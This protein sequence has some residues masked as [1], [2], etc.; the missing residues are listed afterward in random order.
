MMMMRNG[1]SRLASAILALLLATAMPAS[2][3]PF[4][5]YVDLRYRYEYQHHF[6]AKN[7]G[8]QPASGESCDGFW[9]QRLRLG[10]SW[11]PHQ[12]L[13]LAVG[14]QDARVFDSDLDEEGFFYSKKND[15]QNNA[16]RDE[17]E[18]YET[19]VEIREL[20]TPAW[21]LRVGRQT[22]EYGDNRIFGPGSWGNS[23]RYQWD[24]VKLSYR[25]NAHFIDFIWGGY[26]LH[27]PTQLSLRHRHA[28]YG[29]GVYGHWQ[30]NE[31]TVLEPFFLIKYDRHED[32]G[33]EQ[34]QPKGDLQ[35][36]NLGA[37]LAALEGIWFYD[38][39]LVQ[40]WG[41][42]GADRLRAWGAHLLVG[43]RFA[44]LPLQPAL[45]LEYS[46]ASGDADPADGESNAFLGVF[47]ARDRMYGRLNL[48]DWTNLHDAQCNLHL[49]P[50]KQVKLQ[51]E[52][53]RFW[54][55]Q[56]RDGWSLNSSRY[57]DKTGNSG[58][59]L[60]DELDLI[61][62][63]TLPPLRAVKKENIELLFGYSRFWPGEFAEKQADNS[64]ADWL[65]AQISYKRKF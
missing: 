44:H 1:F 19:F 5:G 15:H 8:E 47:G 40:Q 56:E 61:L 7:Y 53:H 58:R 45:S 20:P 43:R 23:G 33:S 38:A 35:A 10:G 55:D 50:H 4:E 13:K 25:R 18:L 54:L 31:K 6:N 62:T 28:G 63:W 2:A 52:G 41:D 17:W 60:G 51:I 29:G 37:R 48:L 34:G 9:L 42:S 39:T 57:R 11:Q 14:L 49:K 36:Y 64:A 21:S 46:F 26:I 32:Y 3:A 65:F 22:L 16:Y 59:H 30:L 27:E 12:H 24:A